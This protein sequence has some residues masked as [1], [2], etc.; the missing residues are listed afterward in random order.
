MFRL[1]SKHRRRGASRDKSRVVRVCGKKNNALF[2]GVKLMS[3][4]LPSSSRGRP[5]TARF[6][7]LA[8]SLVNRTVIPNCV[9]FIILVFPVFLA[10]PYAATG[11]LRITSQPGGALV[12]L[13]ER[14]I[15][16][17]PII[18]R[19]VETGSYKLR[20]T[21]PNSN[22][23]VTQLVE[24]TPDT[25]VNLHIAF[26]ETYGRLSIQTV[27]KGASVSLYTNLG[28]TPIND[29]G[30]IAG[31][32]TLRL[33]HPRN[34]YKTVNHPVTVPA[35]G[36]N[37]VEVEMPKDYGYLTNVGVRVFLGLAAVGSYAWGCA[38]YANDNRPIGFL[39]FGLGTLCVFGVELVSFL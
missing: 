39:G 28:T 9:L 30:I 17:T 12:W 1:L 23:T 2:V 33:E 29:A 18:D 3:L 10:P 16:S 13:D 4:I 25:T 6:S 24:I 15:G 31:E 14:E 38:S 37:P 26:D 27:P 20:L 22:R 35:H 32:Y 8:Y 7:T 19:K 21:D 34:L 5:V 36:I 11:V